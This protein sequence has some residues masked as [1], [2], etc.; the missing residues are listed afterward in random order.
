MQCR[1]QFVAQRPTFPLYDRLVHGDLKTIL[2][3][4]RLSG[5]SFVEIAAKLQDEGIDV[6][7]TTV[8]RWCHD[9]GIEA[10]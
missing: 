8:Y 9:L 4:Y 7:S 10:P 3:D 6:S 1:L 2:T 5:E